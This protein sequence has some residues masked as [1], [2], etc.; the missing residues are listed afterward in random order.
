MNS[1]WVKRA[2]AKNSAGR[3]VECVLGNGRGDRDGEGDANG[4]WRGG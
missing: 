1:R 3:K 2:V 4:M